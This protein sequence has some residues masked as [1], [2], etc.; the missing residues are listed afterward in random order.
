M[1]QPVMKCYFLLQLY[2]TPASHLQDDPSTITTLETLALYCVSTYVTQ[3]VIYYAALTE[4]T[5]LNVKTAEL[6]QTVI[7]SSTEGHSMQTVT[8]A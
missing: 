6:L 4:L 5:T 3:L 2:A 7:T 8:I 1:S